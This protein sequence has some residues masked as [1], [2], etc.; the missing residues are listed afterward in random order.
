[1]RIA[2]IN[3]SPKKHLSIALTDVY[4]IGRTR[5]RDILTDLDIPQSGDG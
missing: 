4:G 5:A 3:I 1:M 2:G